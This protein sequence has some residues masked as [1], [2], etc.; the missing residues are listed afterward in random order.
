M[1]FSD[2]LRGYAFEVH[3]R[4]GFRCVYCGLDGTVWPNWLYLSLDHLLPH[5]H[6]DRD[7][8]VFQVTACRFC[9]EARNRVV[10]VVE[11]RSPAEIVE[12]KRGQVHA[13]RAEYEAFWRE[14]VVAE[15]VGAAADSSTRA[16]LT[17]QGFTGF[18]T[19]AALS[20][21]LA[22]VPVGGGVYAVA[23]PSLDPPR[24]LAA[25]PGGRFEGRDPSVRVTALEAK[26]VEACEVIYIGKGNNLRRRLKQYA[27]FGAGK[28][29]G[30]WGGRYIWQLADANS[31]LVAWKETAPQEIAATA[32]ARL[33][34]AFKRERGTLPFAN[35]A[36]SS[37]D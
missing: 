36:D 1:A 24:F 28:P 12:L 21:R 27:D 26:W 10:Y 14:H 25:S 29:V 33:L 30:H 31:L 20:T 35:I 2:A 34:D 16:G 19:F 32:E 6:P 3:R 18:L 7:D 13:A 15:S 9:N 22:D 37:R 17:A 11:G 8:P 5:G 4:D 23:R